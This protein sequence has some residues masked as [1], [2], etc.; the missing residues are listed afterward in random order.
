MPIKA[1]SRIPENAYQ[2]R[3]HTKSSAGGSTKP[4]WTKDS[5]RVTADALVALNRGK[6]AAALRERFGLATE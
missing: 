3:F 6:E 5:A 1:D 4:P 2:G